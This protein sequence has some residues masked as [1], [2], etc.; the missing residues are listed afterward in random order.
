MS[1][2]REPPAHD[3][4]CFFENALDSTNRQQREAGMFEGLRIDEGWG[5]VVLLLLMLLCV[6][7]SVQAA[8]WTDG[9]AILQGVMIVGASA[10]IVLAKS[11]LPAYMAHALSLLAGFTW[12]AYLTST[13][14]GRALRVTGDVAVIALEGRLRAW[15]VALFS[16]QSSAGTTIFVL[17]LGVLFWLI[18][19][20]SAW[21]IFRWQ[22]VWWAVIISGI[23]IIV[24]LTYVQ[25]KLTL[26]LFAFLILALLLIVRSNLAFSE[27]EWR[28]SQVGYNPEVVYGFL[29]AGLTVSV[30]AILLAWLAPEA[31]ASRPMQEVW[32]KVGEPWRKLQDETNRIFEGLNYDKEPAF[33]S[34][35]D[36]LTR[37]GG[38][39]QLTDAPVMDVR[40]STGRYWRVMA[41]HEYASDG[42]NNTDVD[43]VLIDAAERILDAPALAL[44]REVTQTITLMRDL[45]PLGTI[46]AAGQV[47]RS[48]LPIRALV[49]WIPQGPG[50]ELPDEAP[51]LPP[52]PGDPSAIY[53]QILLK[54][55]D[56]YEVV[57]SLTLADE[58]SLRKAG[59]EYPAWVTPRYLQL[60]DSLPRRVRTLAEELA[61]GQETPYDKARAIERYLRTIPYNDQIEGPRPSQDGVS[62]FLFDAQE[63]YCD[64]YASAMVTM[65][66]SLGIPARYV[67]GYA[68]GSSQEGVFHV[69]EDNAHAW[70]E[71]FFPGYGWVEFEPTAGEPPL[72]RRSSQDEGRGGI[73]EAARRP[74]LP[75]PDDMM[76]DRADMERYSSLPSAPRRS[77]WQQYR[78]WLLGALG[79]AALVSA[80]IAALRLR[81]RRRIQGLSVAERVYEDLTRLA[82]RLF[83]VKPLAHQT[84]HEYGALVAE[85]VLAGQQPVG[86]IVD[87]YV[88]Y[89]FGGR[90][91]AGEEVEEAWQAA[92]RD[93]WGSWMQRQRQKLQSLPRRWFL[94]W[95]GPSPSREQA[96][97]DD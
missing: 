69:L 96:T 24:N 73:S 20:V 77:L 86:Q 31:M 9:L 83:Q 42:W 13:V 45:G 1:L 43:L 26:F 88:G 58:E 60:P 49:S 80:A 4:G 79:G 12:A 41:F 85:T 34:L 35:S 19:Y 37:F 3:E 91:E 97:S 11:R 56:S 82:G 92:Q 66:R 33:V 10:G 7:W 46:S 62:Y 36:R 44:R 27:K 39:V 55:G 6:A 29:R 21:S 2:I 84:P 74:N 59:T 78:Y 53:S 30:V 17:L 48:E 67:R 72:T 5:T 65:L 16:G 50:A 81:R 40:A 15:L 94:P 38:A 89:R 25:G 32:Q 52:L 8:A 75:I 63:G 54:S 76:E 93:L 47:L 51:P 68:N 87:A 23:A 90:T 61:A 57:S 14:L 64:Y 22:Q 95:S 70:P 71:V 18:A 28:R